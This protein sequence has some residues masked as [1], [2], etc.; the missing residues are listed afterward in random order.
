MV[1]QKLAGLIYN[2]AKTR[3]MQIKLVSHPYILFAHPWKEKSQFAI[4]ARIVQDNRSRRGRIF[5]CFEGARVILADD[6]AAMIKNRAPG[7]QR[8]SNIAQ[9]LLRVISEIGS[10]IGAGLL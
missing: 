8:I 6:G 2:L 3:F 10:K 7:L 5:D 9:L 4:S 1:L